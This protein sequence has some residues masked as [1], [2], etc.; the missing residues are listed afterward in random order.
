MT[1][2]QTVAPTKP[3]GTGPDIIKDLFTNGAKLVDDL[4]VYKSLK[5]NHLAYTTKLMKKSAELDATNKS[6][7]NM[8][9]EL[10]K[11]KGESNG[12][13]KTLRSVQE[14]LES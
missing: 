10:K 6:I 5:G 12:I 4:D 11:V 3:K 1:K 13:I 14:E 2:T 8:Q 7:A 9:R